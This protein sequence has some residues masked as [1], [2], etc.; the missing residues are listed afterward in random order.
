[1]NNKNIFLVLIMLVVAFGLFLLLTIEPATDDGEARTPA[2]APAVAPTDYVGLTTTQAVTLAQTNEVI[3]RLVEIDGQ[4]QPV[5]KD[6]R[7]GRINAVV[8]NEIVVS[9]TVEASNSPIVEPIDIPV[10]PAPEPKPTGNDAIIGMTAAEAQTYTKANGIIF[11]VGTID[12]EGQAVTEDYR[13]GRITAETKNDIVIGYTVEGTLSESEPIGN[14]VIIGMTT[15]EASAYAEANNIMFRVGA[16]DGESLSV[17]M[18]Y[19]IG[20]ITV[21]V[22]NDIV[23]GYSVEG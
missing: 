20:R 4:P 18:D 13:P 14:D 12:G 7:P 8:E 2:T 22:A 19:R 3:F 21:E 1:M 10:E 5:T 6:L 11:R 17:T 23:T 16:I 9:Y 15:A